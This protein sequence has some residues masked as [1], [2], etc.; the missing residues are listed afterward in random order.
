[1]ADFIFCTLG[2]NGLVN[3]VDGNILLIRSGLGPVFG[4][5]VICVA[6][7]EEE[8]DGAAERGAIDVDD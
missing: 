8:E 6:K 5:N 2:T 4:S 7:E 1:M 3:P